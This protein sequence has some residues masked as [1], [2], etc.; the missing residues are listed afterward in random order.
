MLVFQAAPGGSCSLGE[1]GDR[2][3]APVQTGCQ[4]GAKGGFTPNVRVEF[5]SDLKTWGGGGY[6]DL[7]APTVYAANNGVI[8]VTLT[9]DRGFQVVLKSFNLGGWQ[10]ADYRVKSVQ[11]IGDGG[12]V[13]FSRRMVRVRG[14]G[15]SHTSFTLTG[16][17]G[18]ALKLRVDSRNLGSS[19]SDN[20]GIDDI[21][22]SQRRR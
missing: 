15:P 12:R 20:V 22:F 9:A 17:A 10:Y 14:A 4:Y 8:Q 1:Y 7:R 13:L 5:L 2:V 21:V 6:G 16:V 11:V 18:R 19:E 3:E